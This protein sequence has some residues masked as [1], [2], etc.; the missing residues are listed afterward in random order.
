MLYFFLGL[1]HSIP[2][3]ADFCPAALGQRAVDDS[4]PAEGHDAIQSIHS[5]ICWGAS[6]CP[7]YIRN[8]FK[9]RWTANKRSRKKLR[10]LVYKLNLIK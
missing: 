1:V 4:E 6:N 5:L 2:Q 10:H 7:V 8:G 9:Q 3:L